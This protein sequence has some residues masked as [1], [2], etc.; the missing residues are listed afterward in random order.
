MQNQVLGKLGS[1]GPARKKGKDGENT[2]RR[3][4][5]RRAEAH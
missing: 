4:T 1:F 5:G 2:N 3:A